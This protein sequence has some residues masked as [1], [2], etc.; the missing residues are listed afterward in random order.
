META[1]PIAEMM[2]RTFERHRIRGS[3]SR[4]TMVRLAETALYRPQHFGQVIPPVSRAGLRHALD[5]LAATV[6]EGFTSEHL[7]GF[8]SSAVIAAR[9]VVR[10]GR[11]PGTALQRKRIVEEKLARSTKDMAR[12]ALYAEFNMAK[13]SDDLLHRAVTRVQKERQKFRKSMRR[14]PVPSGDPLRSLLSLPER[15]SV[16]VLPGDLREKMI[17]PKSPLTSLLRD[18]SIFSEDRLRR[19]LGDELWSHCTPIG[20]ADS[21]RSRVLVEVSSSSVANTMQMRRAEILDRL[22]ALAGFESASELRF[23]VGRSSK[24][25][26]P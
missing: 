6:D 20:F 12:S 16:R 10:K 26:S 24:L 22:R 23:Q 5:I 18:V 8:A 14:L 19:A 1:D 7:R 4:S 13:D 15:G 9:S 3:L 17:D 25:E 2:F 21:R 11:H